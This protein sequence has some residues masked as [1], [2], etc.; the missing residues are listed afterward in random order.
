[1]R[2]ADRSGIRWLLAELPELVASGT[3]SAEAAEALRQHYATTD[4]G[5]PRRIGFVLSAILG[6]LLIGAGIILL[7]AHN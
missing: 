4:S 2:T 6:S 3:L 1:M 7:V 5:E